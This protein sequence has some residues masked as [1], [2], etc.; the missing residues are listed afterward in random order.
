M[1]SEV[2]FEAVAVN[3]FLTA[4]ETR[5]GQILLFVPSDL[6]EAG[7]YIPASEIYIS[8]EDIRKLYDIFAIKDG[9]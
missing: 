2:K 6:T 5:G 3:E 9:E 4:R 8:I 7:H 1:V